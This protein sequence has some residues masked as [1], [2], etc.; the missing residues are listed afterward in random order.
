MIW[1]GRESWYQQGWMKLGPALIA[2][3]QGGMPLPMYDGQWYN[4]QWL[5]EKNGFLSPYQAR[6]QW[7]AAFSVKPAI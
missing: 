5:V 7:N 2:E 3:I 6:E 1:E 4:V